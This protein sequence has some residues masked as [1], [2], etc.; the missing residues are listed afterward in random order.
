[1]DVIT[2][3]ARFK[4]QAGMWTHASTCQFNYVN[5]SR[6]FHV[7]EILKVYDKS[8]RKFYFVSWEGYPDSKNSWI[9]ERSLLRD[10]C[11]VSIDKFWLSK[12]TGISPA[13]EF[14]ADSDN[15]RPRYWM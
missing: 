4:T 1:M 5:T 11:K 12:D 15:N 9:P 6:Y 2:F 3:E 7:E 13:R 8:T 10:G 14:Y